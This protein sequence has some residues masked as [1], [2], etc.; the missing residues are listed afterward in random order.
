MQYNKAGEKLFAEMIERTIGYF[1]KTVCRL[2]EM[3]VQILCRGANLKK[4]QILK[5]IFV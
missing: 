4:I 2:S 5:P 3:G 1:S